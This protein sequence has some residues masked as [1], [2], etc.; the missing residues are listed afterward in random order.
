MS[1]TLDTTNGRSI[2]LSETDTEFVAVPKAEWEHQAARIDELESTVDELYSELAEHQQYDGK[3][4]A[5]ANQRITEIEEADDGNDTPGGHADET[6]SQDAENDEQPQTP[7]EQIC[8][9]PQELAQE[10]LTAN[11]QR[12][13]FV[14]KDIDD[15]GKSVPAGVRIDT[16]DMKRVL[17]AASD[18][19][20]QIYRT[21]VKRVMDFL[22]RFGED[23]VTVKKKRGRRFVIVSDELIERIER[24]KQNRT[25]VCYGPHGSDLLRAT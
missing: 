20:E 10:E 8:S 22:D 5:E 16:S 23:E 15:Y 12:A 25:D 14:A 4:H 7:L 11:Q 6:G 18:E 1:T 21:T 9:L 24:Q 3:R 13:R 19:G 2:D 17:Q